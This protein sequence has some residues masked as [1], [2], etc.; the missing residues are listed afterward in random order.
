MG[1]HTKIFIKHSIPGMSEKSKMH[2]LKPNFNS[3]PR[4]WRRMATPMHSGKDELPSNSMS[5]KW[6]I[7]CSGNTS[8]NIT[9]CYTLSHSTVNTVLYEPWADKIR[10]TNFQSGYY[11]K[12]SNTTQV[13]RKF[14]I[15]VL[16]DS[17]SRIIITSNQYSSHKCRYWCRCKS[18]ISG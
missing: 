18:G 3:W 2:S 14:Y 17:F 5:H 11:M 8:V 12:W 10:L 4:S 15:I 1:K 16:K 9:I 13:I 6:N 7:L